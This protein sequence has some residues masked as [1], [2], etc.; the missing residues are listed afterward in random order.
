LFEGT[1]WQCVIEIYR[2]EVGTAARLQLVKDVI[3]REKPA[4]TMYRLALID[5]TMRVGA[6]TRIG[7]DAIVSGTAGPTPLGSGIGISLAGPL[8]AR[9][10]SSILG[11]DLKL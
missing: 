4:H 10:G 11:K 3:E 5:P 6:Q 7:I 8:P 2:H 1:A 9:I